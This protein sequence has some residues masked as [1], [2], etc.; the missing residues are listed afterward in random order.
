MARVAIRGWRAP[1]AGSRVHHGPQPGGR[2]V[3]AVLLN[4]G[5]DNGQKHHGQDDDRRPKVSQKKGNDGQSQQEGVQRVAK[6]SPEFFGDGGFVFLA[7]T[8]RSE[9]LQT[10][11][12]L[13]AGEALNGRSSPLAGLRRLKTTEGGQIRVLQDWQLHVGVWT[14]R[15]HNLRL[16]HCVPRH[17]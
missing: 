13:G 4:E 10:R 6:A 8:I 2:L 1:D 3:G 14:S 17:G 16:S 12:R 11:L 5:R 9:A 15:L 7:D